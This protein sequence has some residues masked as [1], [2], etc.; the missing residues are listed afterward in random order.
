MSIVATG[1]QA[2]C[3]LDSPEIG[4]IGPGSELVCRYLEEQFPGADLAVQER[5]FH[6][7]NKVS[8]QAS[9]DGKSTRIDYELIGAD[10]KVI[11]SPKVAAP[12]EPT[13]TDT[14]YTMR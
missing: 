8:I 10:W 4:D 11:T 2:K 5:Q 13:G 3:L 7:Q 9:V 6:T 12:V 1:A 14:G